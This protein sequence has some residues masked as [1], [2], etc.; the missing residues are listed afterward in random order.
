MEHK[1]NHELFSI[2]SKF[3]KDPLQEFQEIMASVYITFPGEGRE[4][5]ENLQ[6]TKGR[7]KK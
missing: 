5:Y 7:T 1:E 2:S 3:S 4:G 6:T